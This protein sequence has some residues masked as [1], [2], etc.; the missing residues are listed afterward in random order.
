ML[1]FLS[2]FSDS[3]LLALLAWPFVAA[4][5]TI[6]ILVGQYRRYNK[7][8]FG[9]A[10]LIYF[11][12]LYLIG[13][14]SFT[15][16]P[17]P[18]NPGLFCQD[19][20]LAP[21]LSLLQ[22]VNDIHAGGTPAILQIAM[23]V[24][25]FLPLGFFARILLRWKFAP[26]MLMSF[27]VSLL[28]E[29]A[30]LTGGFGLYPCSYRLFDV[31]DLLFN[32]LGGI[33][34]YVTALLIPRRELERAEKD[35]IVQRAGLLRYFLAFLLDQVIAS[36]F[37]A[38][39]ILAVYAFFGEGVALQSRDNLYSIALI[40]VHIVI[41]YAYNGRSLGSRLVRLTHD[42]TL[43]TFWWRLL[44]Y[45]LRGIVILLLTIDTNGWVRLLTIIVILVCW[46]KW[47]KLPYQLVP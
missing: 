31:D 35:D 38:F 46:R 36:I 6:P 15:L 12:V 22:F 9:R 2:S 19:Y 16:Y 47:K 29:T 42:D 25:L 1:H 30:Q 3:F 32:T 34:G 5:I 24:V 4:I 18:D 21:Q 45:I 27:C 11:F 40:T 37:G 39:I 26:T 13:L 8:I 10:M 44:F 28:I 41:P 43:R 7:V 14:A 23:N 17:M 33:I 20:H